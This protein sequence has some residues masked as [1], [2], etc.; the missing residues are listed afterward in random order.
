MCTS[1]VRASSVRPSGGVLTT[2]RKSRAHRQKV[3]SRRIVAAARG[4]LPA[5]VGML[6][7]VASLPFAQ[8]AKTKFE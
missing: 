3:A 4:H 5:H 8:A 7:W 6:S 1:F 2:A